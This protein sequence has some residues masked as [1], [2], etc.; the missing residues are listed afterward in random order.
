L[1]TVKKTVKTFRR[2]LN[3]IAFGLLIASVVQ[4]LRKPPTERTWHG[5]VVGFVPYDLRIPTWDRVRATF[6]N[7]DN[8]HVV[9]PTVFGV[10]W[11]VNFYAL[12]NALRA[13]R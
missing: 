10:G 3:W 13:A 7:P 8:P 4:E 2:L 6:W 11:S 5:R 12:A 1:T 9:V